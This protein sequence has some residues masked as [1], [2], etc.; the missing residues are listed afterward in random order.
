MS[1]Y[2]VIHLSKVGS[3]YNFPDWRYQIYLDPGKAGLAQSCKKPRDGAG[4]LKRYMQYADIREGTTI[5][6][7][8]PPRFQCVV[9]NLGEK[10][11]ALFY[12]FFH[13]K[14]KQENVGKISCSTFSKDHPVWRIDKIDSLNDAYLKRLLYHATN[15]RY[16]SHIQFAVGF[17][18]SKEHNHL[19]KAIGY[20][21][22]AGLADQEIAR[23]F[24]LY[25][26]QITAIRQL[27]FDFT[28]SPK[29]PTARAAYFTQL[30][31][32]NIITDLD[33]RYYKL[34]AELGELGLK[35][36]TNYHALTTE[37][38]I[39]VEDYLGNTMLDNVF[40]LNFSI[41]DIKDALNFNSVINNL[42]S[43]Y[44]KKEE[45][46]YYRAKV[47]NLDACT[48]RIAN[49]RSSEL[50]NIDSEDEEALKLIGKLA[51]KENSLPDYRAITELN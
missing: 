29:D 26:Q 35:A 20:H 39:L 41:T 22:Y 19:F 21:V 33:R 27:F 9:N 14:L 6:N 31:D 7:S 42:A 16:D 48:Q 37:E 28:H 45:V 36:H 1:K 44:I 8:F 47:R 3:F 12:K 38:K 2:S 11:L 34:I 32:N 25:P 50:V 18:L 17:K 51:L 46:N 15:Y 24:K 40:S 49:D 4:C 43:F 23:R 10:N 30:V 5:N 13:K